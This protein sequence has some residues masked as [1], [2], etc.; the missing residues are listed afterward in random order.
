[1]GALPSAWSNI[2]LFCS[3]IYHSESVWHFLSLPRKVPNILLGRSLVFLKLTEKRLTF[4]LWPA[5]VESHQKI[6]ALSSTSS[7]GVGDPGFALRKPGLA[8]DSTQGAGLSQQSCPGALECTGHRYSC[9]QAC[10]GLWD[11]Q[12]L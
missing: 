10:S 11:E 4:S 3:D 5:C 6:L 2:L 1:M 8:C 7:L 12:C 9:A